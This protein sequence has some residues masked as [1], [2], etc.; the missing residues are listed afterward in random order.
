MVLDPDGLAS[1][2]D[3]GHGETDRPRL[4]SERLRKDE[5]LSLLLFEAGRDQRM[6]VPLTLVTRLEEIEAKSIERAAGRSVTQYRH[7]LLPLA[8]DDGRPA[9]FEMVVGR[10]WPSP[11][12]ATMSAS[13]SMRT[14]I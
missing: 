6:A 3:A 8:A 5:R 11:I 7:S 12:A 13:W 10:P 14:S 4:T 2:L 1:M 9:A